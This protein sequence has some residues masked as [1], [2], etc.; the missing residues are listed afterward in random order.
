M[1]T[2]MS[3]WI[4]LSG[5]GRPADLPEVFDLKLRDGRIRKN[6]RREGV[7]MESWLH[8][9]GKLDLVAYRDAAPRP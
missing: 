1:E 5:L 4:D 3:D 7:P 9:F 6:F 8:R 2:P